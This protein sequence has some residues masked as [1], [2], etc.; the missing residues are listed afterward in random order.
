MTKT[1]AIKK[2]FTVNLAH[3]KIP[4]VMGKSFGKFARAL[5]AFALS[6]K[7]LVV[8]NPAIRKIYGDGLAKS[9]RAKGIAVSLAEIPAGEKSKNL[10][11]LE[12]IYSRC[13]ASGLDRGSVIA[14]LGGGVVGDI[15]GFAAA[16]IYRGIRYVQIP[17]TL[18]AMV[19]SSV[20]GKVGVDLKEGKNLAGV[21][22]QPEFIYVCEEFLKTLPA[23]E[24]KNGLGEVVKYGVISDKRLFEYLE[25][26]ANSRPKWR[27]IIERCLRAKA[28]VVEKDERE[29][30][31]LREILNFGHTY[32]HA[33][34]KAAAY[35]N[36]SHGEAVALGVLKECFLAERLC[37]FKD[38][39][40]VR[41]LLAAL[42]LPTSPP[43]GVTSRAIVQAISA[44]K[45]IR[46]GRIS[47][48]L[49]SS[50]GRAVFMKVPI[51][52]IK[53]LIAESF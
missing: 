38:T 3:K 53:A 4:V 7:V 22:Y 31:G 15:A 12:T 43:S 29:T 5:E 39:D 13:V 11:A 45:K 44:D 6:E 16:T 26:S 40:R 9:L 41:N 19:D 18:L 14:A 20:G 23:Q 28:A 37:G 8:T 24:I 17:T 21:F 51:E 48:F 32:A 47:L 1:F 27:F 33:L 49:P 10:R 30:K 50:I 2:T 46:S 52:E 35:K 36:V 25:N 42:G 34:E